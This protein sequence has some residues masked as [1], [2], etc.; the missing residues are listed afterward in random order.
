MESLITPRTKLI[1]LCHVSNVLGTVNPLQEVVSLAHERGVK[2]LADGAQ[3]IQHIP[4]DVQKLDID[5]YAFSSHKMYGSNGVGILY[6]KR[7]LLETMPPYQGG[8][9]MIAEVRFSGTT[10]NELPYKFEAGTPH[11]SGVVGFGAAL[12]FLSEIGY[13]KISMHEQLLMNKAT[14]ELQEFGGITIY[15]NAPEKS[16][17]ISFS[18]EGIH[19]YD[20][21]MLL[22]KMGIAVR[23]GHHCA[24]PVMEHYGIPGTVRVSFAVYNMEEE[25]S[26]FMEALF[27]VRKML[28]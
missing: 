21:G 18:M 17:V 10:Y 6:G 28:T 2:V 14:R 4:I 9:E 20:A 16:G 3:A 25:I 7:E 22:D 27:K 26:R 1:A 8:G 5:F 24:D 13:E 19:P 12:S 23:T 15:G 11:I